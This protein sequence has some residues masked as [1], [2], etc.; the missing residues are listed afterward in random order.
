ML[1]LQGRALE[2]L[3]ARSIARTVTVAE[4][5]SCSVDA[6]SRASASMDCVLAAKAIALNEVV[7]QASIL[8]I[9]S[10]R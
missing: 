10:L 1:V 4:G 9:G 2:K 8:S 7:S 3:A 5:L 6:E